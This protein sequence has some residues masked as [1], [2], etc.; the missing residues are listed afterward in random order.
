MLFQKP[1]DKT[2]ESTDKSK[3]ISTKTTIKSPIEVKEGIKLS[4]TKT[5]NKADKMEENSCKDVKKEEPMPSYN[6]DKAN[7]HPIEDSFWKY[8]Q[9]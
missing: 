6:P 1:E 4:A 2:P 7:Y 8:G 5:E 9:K 3:K